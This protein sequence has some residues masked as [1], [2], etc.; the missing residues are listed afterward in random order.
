MLGRLRMLGRL[1]WILAA[2][3]LG[4]ITGVALGYALSSWRWGGFDV[5]IVKRAGDAMGWAALG[6]MAAGAAVL[7]AIRLLSPNSTGKARPAPRTRT[8]THPPA[9]ME[10]A[11]ANGRLARA[12]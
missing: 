8:R 10:A 5:W 7:G 9:N 1:H 3:V 2:I 6:A 4:A 11:N 12:S